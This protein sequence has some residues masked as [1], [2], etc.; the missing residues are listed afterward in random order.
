MPW[1]VVGGSLR[2][3]HSHCLGG[4]WW[5]G[6]EVPE[7]KRG[8]GGALGLRPRHQKGASSSKMRK[9]ARGAVEGV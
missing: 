9:V 3:K 2:L 4:C 1:G 5:T 7:M 6:R 8:S